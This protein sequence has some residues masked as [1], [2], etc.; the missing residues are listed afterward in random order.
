[1]KPLSNAELSRMIGDIYDCAVEPSRWFQ[2]LDSIR[3]RLE[4]AFLQL[5]FTSQDRS[6]SN[7]LPD[8]ITFQTD[9]DREWID[10]LPAL[11][12]IMPGV[13]AWF[14]AEIDT[15]ISQ[16]QLL[17]E[18]EFRTSEF[19]EAWVKPQGL[20]DTC[21]TPLFKRKDL[22]GM[23]VATSYEAR[24][25][26]DDADREI[27]ALLSPH[28]RRALMISGMRAENRFRTDL[29]RNLLDKLAT[30][31]V[32]VAQGGRLAYANA[33]GE[34]L[35][36]SGRNI[37]VRGGRVQAAHAPFAAGF[38]EAVERACAGN[39]TDIGLYGNGIPLPSREGAP[40]VCYVLPLGKSESRQALGP[41]LAALFISTDKASLP[42]TI[43]A[44]SALTGLTSQE[45]RIALMISSGISPKD[46]AAELG[47]SLNT[48]RS[49]ITHIFQKTG[50]N[51]Q[52]SVAR[53]VSDLSLPV[54]QA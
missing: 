9:W 7:R 22:T 28:V 1:V 35:L 21:N 3:D 36:S 40:A 8:M 29:Q 30:G 19:C 17:P 52:Q 41:G 5:N 12:H 20:R 26:F 37:T 45:A 11:L 24:E 14:D 53:L 50:V 18:D 54:L 15:P 47:I 6:G 49:H 31:I 44:L 34:K 2:T 39:D 43:E 46:G 42:P 13:N 16:M 33:S 10:K 25:L 38:N 48:I 32:I 4:L 27:F 51:D 23:L